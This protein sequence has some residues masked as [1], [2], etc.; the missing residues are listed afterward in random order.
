MAG[1]LYCSKNKNKAQLEFSSIKNAEVRNY[2]SFIL[3][4]M[5]K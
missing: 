1:V 5:L 2:W 4:K 3:L